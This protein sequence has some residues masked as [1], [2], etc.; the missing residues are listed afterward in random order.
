MMTNTNDFDLYSML[1]KESHTII[2]LTLLLHVMQCLRVG[3]AL[4][5]GVKFKKK[6]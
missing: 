5:V 4:V 6:L 3:M 2:F 1:L